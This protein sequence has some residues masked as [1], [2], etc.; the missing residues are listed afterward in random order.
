M[1]TRFEFLQVFDVVQLMLLRV[2][3]GLVDRQC[4]SSRAVPTT[5]AV[6][7]ICV[8]EIRPRVGGETDDVQQARGNRA[9]KLSEHRP[10]TELSTK[11]LTED[12]LTDLNKFTIAAVERVNHAYSHLAVLITTGH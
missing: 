2:Y 4:G 5:K 12:G 9:A 11:A 10:A 3:E 8:S 7:L 1:I 6:L